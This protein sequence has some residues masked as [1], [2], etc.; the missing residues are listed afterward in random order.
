MATDVTPPRNRLIVL[1]AV[2]AALTLLALK[3]AF[4]AYFDTMLVSATDQG[5]AIGNDLADIQE[6]RLQWALREPAIEQ[7]MQQIARE[8]RTAPPSSGEPAAVPAWNLTAPATPQAPTADAQ[9]E[10]RLQGAPQTTGQPIPPPGP[11]AAGS[12]PRP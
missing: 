3:P 12:T 7:A 6:A 8:G 5:L 1:Y 10:P 9:A 2:L 11:E 4:D